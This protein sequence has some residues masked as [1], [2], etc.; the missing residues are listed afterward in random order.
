MIPRSKEAI[1]DMVMG[2]GFIALSFIFP[3]Q[4]STEVNGI[5]LGVGLGWL[6]K[7]VIDHLK[8]VKSEA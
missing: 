2:G 6:I 8:G 5:V 4:A 3:G 1:K 7:S